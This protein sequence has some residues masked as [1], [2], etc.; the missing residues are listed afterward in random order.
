M[1]H[2]R[3][4]V[5]R[6]PKYNRCI[7]QCVSRFSQRLAT[8]ERRKCV[9]DKLVMAAACSGWA[10][11]AGQHRLPC[12]HTRPRCWPVA[13][14]KPPLSLSIS[15]WRYQARQPADTWWLVSAYGRSKPWHYDMTNEAGRPCGINQA[16]LL[17][18][19]DDLFVSKAPTDHLRSSASISSSLAPPRSG[20]REESMEIS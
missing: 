4:P 16:S 5:G 15:N 11:T 8:A 9:R 18:F 12:R 17:R 2:T 7:R 10:A 1:P 19:L 6:V 20:E 14:V 3:S 13:C